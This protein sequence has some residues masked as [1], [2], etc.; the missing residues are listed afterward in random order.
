MK[1]YYFWYFWYQKEGG[2]RPTV[3]VLYSGTEPIDENSSS[4]LGSY[5][6]IGAMAADNSSIYAHV[7]KNAGK[8]V[9]LID[10]Q[11]DNNWIGTVMID[12]L[13]YVS[14]SILSA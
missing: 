12:L 11:G 5:E 1:I 7:T 10:W 13:Q 14:A 8:S 6:L 9:I 3:T 4:R 2:Q